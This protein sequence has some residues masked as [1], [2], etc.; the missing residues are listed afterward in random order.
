VVR[1]ASSNRASRSST[2]RWSIAEDRSAS[3]ASQMAS[4]RS[5]TAARLSTVAARPPRWSRDRRPRA[6]VREVTA[7]RRIRT[8]YRSPLVSTVVK[9]TS[10]SAALSISQSWRSSTVGVLQGGFSS[11]GD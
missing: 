4:S 1:A 6:T 7:A 8:A 5:A 3:L 9:A 10:R 11:M 2:R